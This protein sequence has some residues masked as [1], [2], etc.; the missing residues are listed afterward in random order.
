LRP[1]PRNFPMGFCVDS[2][3]C[4]DIISRV[5]TSISDSI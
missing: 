3:K 2:D 1:R 5:L 4:F